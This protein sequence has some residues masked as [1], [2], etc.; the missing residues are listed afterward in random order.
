MDGKTQLEH[1]R[2]TVVQ[3][4]EDGY[5]R[6]EIA[7]AFEVSLSSVGRF[8]RRWR[9]TGSVSPEK[10]GGYKGYALAGRGQQIEQRIAE[11]PDIT[12]AELRV[13]LARRKVVV[14]KSSI[15][16]F[17]NHLDLTP[18]KKACTRGR[19]RSARAARPLEDL[20]LHLRP[21]AMI[22]SARLCCYMDQ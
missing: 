17:L 4:I 14:G 5:T 19:T 11:C 3:A 16:R 7:E 6:E 12:L 22:V 1:L 15:A 10:F 8:V 20:D 2:R 13:W 21:C 9:T 18:L